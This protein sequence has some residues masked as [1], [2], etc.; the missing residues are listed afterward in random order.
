MTM[1]GLA[2]FDDSIH[3]TNSWLKALMEEL[4]FDDRADAYHALRDTLH[5]LRDRLPVGIATSLAAQ[6]PMLIRGFYYE[7]WRPEAKSGHPRTQ[8][9]FIEDVK[10]GFQQT[11]MQRDPHE[12]VEAVLTL[13]QEKISDG[14][15]NKVKGC[16]PPQIRSLWP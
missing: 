7:G 3:T 9:A 6:M 1:T 2:V 10:H 16:L 14:E 5:A 15:I 13:L 11:N 4:H 8:E 12:V